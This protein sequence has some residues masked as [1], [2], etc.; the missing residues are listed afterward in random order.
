MSNHIHIDE[1]RERRTGKVH[2]AIV[3]SSPSTGLHRDDG[4]ADLPVVRL[5]ESRKAVA[6]RLV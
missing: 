6:R 4:R 5:G 1:D 2:D 3:P